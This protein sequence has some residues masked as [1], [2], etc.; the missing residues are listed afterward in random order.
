MGSAGFI[1][2]AIGF[3]LANPLF[4]AKIR[5]QASMANGS[6]K[7]LGASTSLRNTLKSEGILGLYRG[8]GILMARGALLSSGR[9]AISLHL[10]SVTF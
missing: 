5:V 9:I 8:S 4:Q 6:A 2:G 1:A 3:W 10:W 7:P